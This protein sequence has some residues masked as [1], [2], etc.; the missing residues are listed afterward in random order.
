MRSAVLLYGDLTRRAERTRAGDEPVQGYAEVPD[1][2]AL[3]SC[4]YRAG[5]HSIVLIHKV[6]D[7]RTSG[8][9]RCA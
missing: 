7:Q 9:L 3:D 2:K 5:L 6:R 8:A 1:A 4:E